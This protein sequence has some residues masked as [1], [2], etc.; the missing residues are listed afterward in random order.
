MTAAADVLTW[1][2]ERARAGP[3]RGDGRIAY[4]A[5]LPQGP[6]PS[7]E[8]LRRCLDTLAARGY[9]AV[10]TSALAPAESQ[11]FFAVGFVEQER[12]RLLSHDLHRLPEAPS[13][14]LRKGR[15][16]DWP[17]VLEV[18]ASAFDRFWR[19]DRDGLDEALAATPLT[20]FR[21][22]AGRS[23]VV[24]YAV[25]GRAGAEGYLQRLAVAPSQ[26]RAGLGTALV[27]DGL[28]WMRRWKVRRA[29]VN[30][31]MGNDAA[32][33]LYLRLGFEPE[34]SDLAVLHADLGR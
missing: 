3:W 27:V 18:D 24:G 11:A 13:A 32:L 16:A 10:L 34:P 9:T 21:V 23:T 15:E 19:L 12:L 29:V 1:G 7:V 8:F 20:R 26:R 14:V 2:R 6:P 31:Q 28:R 22:A 5:P 30:T 17:R 25:S 4:L 33:A